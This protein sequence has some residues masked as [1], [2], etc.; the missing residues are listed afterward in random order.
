MVIQMIFKSSRST[1][2]LPLGLLLDRCL[3]KKMHGK[4]FRNLEFQKRRVLFE[5]GSQHV[6]T[7]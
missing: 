3:E 7:S 5:F 2:K 4:C 1:L 6:L